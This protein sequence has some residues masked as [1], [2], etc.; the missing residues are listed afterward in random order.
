MKKKALDNNIKC[1]YDFGIRRDLLKQLQIVATIR[2]T[3][4]FDYIIIKNFYLL[5]VHR[6]KSKKK[7]QNVFATKTI[8]SKLIL[9]MDKSIKKL[10][11]NFTKKEYSDDK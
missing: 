7:K 10:N 6:T 9:R 8:K 2:M 1:L 11:R 5:R 3:N 4:I